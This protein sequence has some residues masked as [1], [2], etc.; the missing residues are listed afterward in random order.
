VA[1]TANQAV[2]KISKAGDVTSIALG[3]SNPESIAVDSTG[4]VYVTDSL[5][6]HK[7]SDGKVGFAAAPA[8]DVQPRWTDCAR[9]QRRH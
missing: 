6:I 9:R 1:D 5:G 2:R 7:I 3:L 4:I 8:A